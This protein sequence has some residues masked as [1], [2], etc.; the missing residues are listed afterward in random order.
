MLKSPIIIARAMPNPTAMPN[1]SRPRRGRL[2]P[3]AIY[4]EGGAGQ[5]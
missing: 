3:L 4:G 2:F 1:Q 5:G